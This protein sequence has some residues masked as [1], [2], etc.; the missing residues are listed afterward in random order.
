LRQGIESPQELADGYPREKEDL[1]RFSAV[2]FG[3]VS[4]EFFSA[5]QLAMTREFVSER[6][7][8]LLMLGGTTALDESYTDT[9]IAD[10]LPVTLLPA[11][12]QPPQ[13]RGDNGRQPAGQKFTLRLTPEGEQA[14]LLRLGISDEINRQLWEKMPQ[15][16]GI[17]VTGPAKPGATVLAEHSTLSFRGRPLPVIAY[18]RYGRGRTMVITTA[19]TWRWQ[20]L[21]PHDDLSHERFW[22]Q[23]LRWLAAAAPSQVELSLDQ[24]A[25]AAGE[26][27][28]VRLSV[29]D[30]TY[31]PV[32]DASVWLKVTGP[33]G[34]IRDIPLQWA[35][36][37]DGIYTGT[38]TAGSEGIH[39]IEAAATLS[40]GEVSLA[41]TG[42]LV[43]ESNAEYIDAG[44][45][46][47]LLQKIAVGSGGKFYADTDVNQLVDD[48]KRRQK[49]VTV[50]NQQ[51]IWDIPLVLLTLFTL[52]TVEWWV[53]RRRGLS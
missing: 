4:K 44:A 43:A 32:N 33:D 14:A 27:V 38:F 9:P 36:E 23:V 5:D 51:D 7:G 42:F 31:A 46:I 24:D 15:L 28:R 35:I 3:D 34:D 52:L 45:D 49:T 22:R 11:A 1:Y 30:R 53:R 2:I 37:E 21:L 47:G 41:A 39:Q 29:A 6:G 17:S 8:G 12:Q 18:Q 16:E 25:Y 13:L 10:I 19:T 50:E 40:S 26:Q 48:L 20:M